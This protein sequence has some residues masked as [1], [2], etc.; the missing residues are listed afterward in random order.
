MSLTVRY[1]DT[2]V[3][4]SEA[5][6]VSSGAGQSFS[7]YPSVI[8]GAADIPWATLESN[9]WV[10]DG[11]R[12]LLSEEP[13]NMGWWS[14]QTS[15]SDGRF[16]TP[17]S[18]ELAFDAP[19]SATALSFAF[20]PSTG[21]WCSEMH[22]SWYNGDTLRDEVTVFPDGPQWLLEHVVESFD[23]VTVEIMETNTANQFAKIQQIQIGRVVTFGRDELVSVRLLNEVDPSLCELSV[24]TLRI[25]IH[26]Q[27][28]LLVPQENQKMEL[29]RDDKLMATQYIQESSREAKNYYTFSCQSAVGLLDSEFLGGIYIDVP[30][31]ALL[32]DVMDGHK[33]ILDDT[34]IS[35]TVNGY[36]PICTR[37]EALQQIAFALGAMVTTQESDA[38]RLIPVPSELDGSFSEDQIFS[39]AKVRNAPRLAQ[40]VLVSHGYTP[41]P[42]EEVLINAEQISGENVL[43]TF[44]DPYCFY[45]INGGKLT[46]S[47]ANWVTITADGEVSLTARPY[48]HTATRYVRR[49]P[50]ATAAERGN[51]LTVDEAT[52]IHSGNVHAALNRL[53][54]AKMMRQT[55]THEAVISGHQAGQVVSSVNP[56]GTSTRGY[57]NSKESTLTQSG[58]TAQ[59]E[60]IGIEVTEV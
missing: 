28:G 14:R 59:V 20:W 19:Y 60:I 48:L 11:S 40:V 12:K 3:G 58:H 43:I 54:T 9:S 24:D 39:G 51:I 35:E 33:Y 57:I 32:D 5:A 26:N 38:I 42:T 6:T 50:E 37:R 46:D 27:A 56:W 25:E 8:D 45:N 15:G 22:V 41:G 34:F 13:D 1:I 31:K 29:Y 2:P 36:L 49:N 53:Y 52:L 23:K 21:Q 44:N 16:D 55:L 10:L 4:A 7:D 17:P 30:V 18:I 47:D